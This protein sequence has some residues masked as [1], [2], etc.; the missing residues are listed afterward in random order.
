AFEL[1]K[2]P[3]QTHLLRSCRA[4]LLRR[5]VAPPHEHATS[6]TR[7]SPRASDF[8][9][10]ISRIHPPTITN[11]T[12]T[13]DLLFALPDI[14]SFAPTTNP[15]VSSP[16]HHQLAIPVCCTANHHFPALLSSTRPQQ[17]PD[18]PQPPNFSPPVLRVARTP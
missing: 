16:I 4:R 9:P 14:S 11:R 17:L 6:P 15:C 13:A 2:R 1:P 10:H 18:S 8:P 3:L 12:S 5:H 7:D